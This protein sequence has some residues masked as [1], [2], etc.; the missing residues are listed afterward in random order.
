M[1]EGWSRF[2][3]R[4]GDY[5]KSLDHNQLW[6]PPRLK[7]REWMFIP[8]GSRPPDRHRGFLNK[9]GLHDYLIQKPPHSCF[10]S[11]AYYRNPNERKMVD[12]DWLGADLIFDLDG[13]H[14]PGVSDNDFPTMISMIQDQA[15]TLWTEFLQPEFGFEEKYVQTSFSGHRGFHIH[16]RDPSLLHLDSNARRQLVNYIRGEGINVQTILSGPNSGWQSRIHNG[17]ESVTHK[18][19]VIKEK[20][21]DH[22]SYIEQLQSAVENTHKLSIRSNKK[23]SKA[24]INEIA[25]MTDDERIGR[26]LDN[27]KLRVFGEK[28]TSL[29]WDMVK[30]DNSVVL[31]SAGET[32]EA[33]TVDVKRVI[34]WIGSLHGKCGLRVTEMPLERLNPDSSNYFD[35]LRE[36]IVFSSDKKFNILLNKD[37]VT[38]ELAGNRIQ[39]DSG[40]RFVVTESLATFLVLKGWGSII[41]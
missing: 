26:I 14:L 1:V 19:K 4:F 41:D 6:V 20:G 32:D 28:N 18:L 39:G 31:G 36:S 2:A 27:N 12:K 34:R 10:H 35:P 13:D 33:V 24:K 37:D 9:R 17:I 22:K 30:G 15:W 7:S 25:D 38:A 29:F 3:L 5:Y 16:V 21:P 8:W 40:D 23:V 11:T